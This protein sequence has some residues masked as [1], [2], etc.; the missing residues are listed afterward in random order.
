MS[1][2]SDGWTLNWTTAD[3]TARESI[4][5]AIA[6]Q[7]GGSTKLKRNASLSGLGASGPFF[8]DALAA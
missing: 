4:V 5:V 8:H 1:L 6:Q 2:D 3:G 7:A